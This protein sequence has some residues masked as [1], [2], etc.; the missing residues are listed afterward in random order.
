M[1]LKENNNEERK[2]VIKLFNT[3]DL[4]HILILNK[5]NKNAKKKRNLRGKI[6]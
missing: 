2:G 6:R 5:I 1:I 3:Y 4:Q